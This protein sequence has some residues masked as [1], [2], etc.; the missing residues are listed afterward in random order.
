METS[1]SSGSAIPKQILM[2]W[3]I[4]IIPMT[5]FVGPGS[6]PNGQDSREGDCG[7]S[8]S[9]MARA[10]GPRQVEGS[11]TFVICSNIG[12]DDRDKNFN[13]K[14]LDGRGPECAGH[15]GVRAS[16]RAD[17]LGAEAGHGLWL[18]QGG[19]DVLLQDGHQQCRAALEGRQEGA[20]GHAVLHRP[21]RSAL[22]AHRPLS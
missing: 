4:R 20:E 16:R 15:I 5:Y 1:V 6:R 13:K 11:M 22:Y 9:L 8:Q 14:L 7:K 12:E 19:K 17:T 21:Q 3:F 10:N 18:R 2:T